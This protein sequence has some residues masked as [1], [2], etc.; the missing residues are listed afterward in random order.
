MKRKDNFLFRAG[1][2]NMQTQSCRGN[3]GM[4]D[5]TLALVWIRDNIKRFKGD[6]KNVTIAGHGAAAA[7]VNFHLISPLSK[8]KNNKY[9][10]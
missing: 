7:C 6:P 2:L 8:S 5:Q 9:A 10:Q 4:K 1:F 3:T